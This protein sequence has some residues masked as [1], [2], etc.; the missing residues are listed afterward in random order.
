MSLFYC[1]SDTSRFAFFP[2]TWEFPHGATV[3]I[4]KMETFIGNFKPGII[5]VWQWNLTRPW[6]FLDK[7]FSL[8]TWWIIDPNMPQRDGLLVGRDEVWTNSSASSSRLRRQRVE[9]QITEMTR[10]EKR[11]LVFVSVSFSCDVSCHLHVKLLAGAEV[12]WSL[13]ATIAA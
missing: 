4:T 12:C 6:S 7:F 13:W 2:P 1:E 10:K 8:S 9:S 3:K 5:L 11:L